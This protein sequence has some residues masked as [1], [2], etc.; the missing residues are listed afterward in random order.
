VHPEVCGR[1]V[2]LPAEALEELHDAQVLSV[3]HLPAGMEPP[4]G[5]PGITSRM[6]VRGR[7][8]AGEVV[9]A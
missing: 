6:G 2:R 4:M 1:N 8:M 9:A 5:E 7:R 3:A